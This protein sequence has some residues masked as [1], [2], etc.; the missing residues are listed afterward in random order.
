MMTDR[1][2]QIAVADELINLRKG[3][4]AQ[5][6]ELDSSGQPTLSASL[7]E[8]AALRFL[9]GPVET[10]SGAV[11]EMLRNEIALLSSPE[12]REWLPVSLGVKEKLSTASPKEL[13]KLASNLAHHSS[14]NDFKRT[15][16]K[17]QRAFHV[18]AARIV[19]DCLGPL[20][21]EQDSVSDVPTPPMAI[22]RGY[23][24]EIVDVDIFYV[25]R[26]IIEEK[27]QEVLNESR[28][29]CLVGEG[30]V[31]KTVLAKEFIKSMPPE[32]RIVLR[33]N[34]EDSLL[35][36]AIVCLNID[37]AS[38]SANAIK[39]RLRQLLAS[40]TDAPSYVVFDDVRDWR[41]MQEILPLRPE[42]VVLVTARQE[43]ARAH[44]PCVEVGSLENGE[45]F[46]LVRHIVPDIS[47][48]AMR[49]IVQLGGRVLA[50]EQVCGLIKH[51]SDSERLTFLARLN[52]NL[53]PVLNMAAGER[54]TASLVTVYE[55]I[56][57]TMAMRQEMTHALA[58]L[59][60]VAFAVGGRY[61]SVF[62]RCMTHGVDETGAIQYS[63][64]ERILKRLRLVR[65]DEG[66]LGMHPITRAIL[67]RI[68][69]P[70]LPRV[71]IRLIETAEQELL[72]LPPNRVAT[73]PTDDKDFRLTGIRSDVEDL[74]WSVAD[75]A[76]QETGDDVFIEIRERFAA[77]DRGRGAFHR[78]RHYRWYGIVESRFERPTVDFAPSNPLRR[79]FDTEDGRVDNANKMGFN[80][81]RWKR[82]SDDDDAD[83]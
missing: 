56:V 62:A 47:R 2:L 11:A 67:R 63:S 51:Q 25:H 70:E 1:E 19:A 8:K 20:D 68:F 55:N 83:G 49:S 69:A 22:A 82:H 34:N 28:I 18:L 10:R 7:L 9:G 57:E 71:C 17:L 52:Q 39:A 79:I 72:A 33:A 6:D 38:A 24:S 21:P 65:G 41:L 40:K 30:G 45:V 5:L 80:L 43:F 44:V 16:G 81:E 37:E 58:L 42:S 23:E 74:V 32:K 60:Y 73:Y 61:S 75:Y 50:V 15:G 64:A 76:Y 14:P 26:P 4:I 53:V 29:V 3:G 66:A 13:N 31:G 36:D 77:R 78:L 27:L 46:E 35:F 59:K 54:D 48:A 12:Y